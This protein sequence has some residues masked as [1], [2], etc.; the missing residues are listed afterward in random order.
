MVGDQ[1][2]EVNRPLWPGQI[3]DLFYDLDQVRTL[4]SPIRSLVFWSL[5]SYEAKS[6]TDVAV[7]I[8]KTAQTVRYHLSALL[9]LDLIMPLSTRKKRSRTETLYVRKARRS[10]TRGDAGPEYNRY[11]VRSIK[12]E[13][14]KIIREVA[15]FYGYREHDLPKRAFSGYRHFHMR[16]T[17]ERAR[18]LE[19]DMR[20]L[21]QNAA[22]AQN[23]DEDGTAEV[24]AFSILVPTLPQTRAWA[25]AAGLNFKDLNRDGPVELDDDEPEDL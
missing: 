7:E 11:I 6:A 22:E 20:M 3:E 25:K 17:P 4:C 18:K 16:L 19:D 21:L 12:L 10:L 2:S 5:D 9:K 24:H 15:H 13:T 23:I 14:Q 8:G 1:E